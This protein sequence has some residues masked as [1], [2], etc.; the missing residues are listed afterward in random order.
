MSIIVVDALK[1]LCIKVQNALRIEEK[2]SLKEIHIWRY[3]HDKDILCS[4]LY[5]VCMDVIFE[6]PLSEEAK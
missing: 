6:E 4:F 3:V 5:Y 2:W 1:L